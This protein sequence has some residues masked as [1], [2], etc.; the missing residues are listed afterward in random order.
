[1]HHVRLR[2]GLRGTGGGQQGRGDVARAGH[3]RIITDS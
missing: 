2:T 1:M 3:P